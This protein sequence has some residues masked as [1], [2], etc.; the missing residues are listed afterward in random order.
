LDNSQADACAVVWASPQAWTAENLSFRR[1]C[2]A[3]NFAPRE[4]R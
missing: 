1:L 4:T 3:G 2:G